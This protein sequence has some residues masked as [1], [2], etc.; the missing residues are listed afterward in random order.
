MTQIAIA[1]FVAANTLCPAQPHK[2]SW[3]LERRGR[4]LLQTLQTAHSSPYP[5]IYQSSQ[6]FSSFPQTPAATQGAQEINDLFFFFY[7]N[8]S[9]CVFFGG[10]LVLS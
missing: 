2:L 3:A 7:K 6:Y 4:T 5:H 10:R 9:S 1:V 8:S